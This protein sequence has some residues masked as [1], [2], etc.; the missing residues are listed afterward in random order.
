MWLP[1]TSMGEKFIQLRQWKQNK[2][3]GFIACTR[4]ILLKVNFVGGFTVGLLAVC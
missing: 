3:K 4:E 1:S 2:N